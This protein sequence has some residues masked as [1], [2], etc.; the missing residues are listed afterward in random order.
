MLDKVQQ[1]CPIIQA[2]LAK[3]SNITTLAL[4]Q[5]KLKTEPKKIKSCKFLE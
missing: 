5:P 1:K 4:M 2:T 3:Q